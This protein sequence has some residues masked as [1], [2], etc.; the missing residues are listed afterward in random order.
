M[1]DAQRT[2]ISAITGS[3]VNIR[4]ATEADR[5]IDRYEAARH[6][7]ARGASIDPERDEIVVAT[8]EGKKRR[9]LAFAALSF[10]DAGGRPEEGRLTVV[11]KG[12]VRGMGKIVAQHLVEHAPVRTLVTDRSTSRYL[13]ELGFRRIAGPAVRRGKGPYVRMVRSESRA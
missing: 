5:Y 11:E 12:R 3:I 9:L 8:Q 2:G 10:D 6:S 4:H 1:R 7:V 13:S